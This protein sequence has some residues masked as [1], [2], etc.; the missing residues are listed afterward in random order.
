MRLLKRGARA[1]TR[2]VYYEDAVVAG[3]HVSTWVSLTEESYSI[4]ASG[5][6]FYGWPD[7]K[8]LI[9]QEQCVV[10]ILKIILV[11]LIKEFTD[12]AA[13]QS[14]VQRRNS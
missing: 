13:K 2:G 1:A 3:L 10:D 11:E 4:G 9:D 8:P 14:R 5:Y 6:Q 7:G 12:G